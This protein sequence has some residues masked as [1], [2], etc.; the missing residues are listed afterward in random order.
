VRVRA[1]GEF[2]LGEGILDVAPVYEASPLAFQYGLVVYVANTLASPAASSTATLPTGKSW[3]AERVRVRAESAGLPALTRVY[4]VPSYEVPV[5]GN[6]AQDLTLVDRELATVFRD[7]VPPGAAR[8]VV[9]KVV[10]EGATGDGLNLDSNEWRFPLRVCN[11]CL[12]VPACTAPAV[13]TAVTCPAIP[14]QDF[15]P[16]CVAPEAAPAP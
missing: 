12:P 5:A 2:Q 7:A 10:I 8:Q 13:A 4:E 16:V 1:G 3:Y 11:G 9:L 15:P 6:I 14:G